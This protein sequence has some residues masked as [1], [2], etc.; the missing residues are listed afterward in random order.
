MKPYIFNYSEKV[1]LQPQNTYQ[2]DSTLESKIIETVDDDEITM[3]TTTL[4]TNTVENDDR[5]ELN[6]IPYE[7]TIITKTIE[8]SDD[9]I[10]SCSTWVTESTEPADSDEILMA[11]T[12]ITRTIESDDNDDIN[13]H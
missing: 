11:S 13:S 9:E 12:L 6:L 1:L 7:S 4:Q 5:D 8:P 10:R 3:F 2:L